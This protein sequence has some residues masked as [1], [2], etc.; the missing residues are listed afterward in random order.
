MNRLALGMMLVLSA[1]AGPTVNKQAPKPSPATPP[2][3]TFPDQKEPP[4]PGSLEALMK[5]HAG[6]LEVTPNNTI[7]LQMRDRRVNILPEKE[8]FDRYVIEL[9]R[10]L[11]EYEGQS[12]SPGLTLQ[13]LPPVTLPQIDQRIPDPGLALLAGA[14]R[15][16][17]KT[18]VNPTTGQKIRHRLADILVLRGEAALSSEDTGRDSGASQTYLAQSIQLYQEL[19]RDDPAD[20][21]ND[22]VL[23]QLA[24]AYALTGDSAASIAA[25]ARLSA[26][27]PDSSHIPEAEFRQAEN[28]F[29]S[30]DY[31]RADLAYTRVI[32]YGENTPYYINARYMQGWSRLE[33]G[34]YHGAVEPLSLTLDQLLPA[35]NNM[36]SMARGERELAQDSLRALAL[37]FSQLEGAASINRA[38]NRLGTRSYQ[39]LI[40]LQLGELYLSQERY[41]DSAETYKSYLLSFP[42]A[43]AAPGVQKQVIE[44]YEAGGF[45]ELVAQEKQRY[46]ELFGINATYWQHRGEEST[47]ENRLYVKQLTRE[48]ANYHHALAQQATSP[49]D[50]TLSATAKDHYLA[51]IH[52]YQSFVDH[53]AQD[54]FA[55]EMSFL[56]GEC[57]SQ[58]G[59]YPGAITAY[60]WAAYEHSGDKRAAE[61]AYA[62][63]LT[64]EHLDQKADPSAPKRRIASARRFAATLANDPRAPVVLEHAAASLLRLN[65]FNEST[66]LATKVIGWQPT[67]DPALLTAAHLVKGH[68]L[69]EMH[70]YTDAEQTYRQAL[71]GLSAND[72]RYPET[73]DRLAASIYR[74]GELAANAGNF[75]RAAQEFERV[76][77]AAP[78]SS[79]RISA[80]F[81]AAVNFIQAGELEHANRLLLDFRKR[82]PNHPLTASTGT[83]LLHNYEQLEQWQA[84]ATEL[85]TIAATN[86][87][88]EAGREAL[89]LSASYYERAGKTDLA[90]QRYRRYVQLWPK[91]FATALEAMNRLAE[92]YQENG[93]LKKRNF[94]LARIM[95]A[96][97]RAGSAQSERSLYL[98]ARASSI[99]A[100]LEYQ[101]FVAIKL[102]YPLQ[103]SLAH[104]R[105][106]L[107]RAMAAY[108]KTQAYG[109]QQFGT[110]ATYRM[111]RIYQQLSVDLLRS[112]RPRGLDALALQQYD[113]LLE[114]Q[115]YPFEEKAIAIYET[116]ARRGRDGL[117]DEWVR[118][119]FT[120]LAELLPAR[121]RKQEKRYGY[122]GEIY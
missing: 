83:K 99:L 19:L 42:D 25:L 108:Q 101:Q 64:Y 12:K 88:Q 72:D 106:A 22:Q 43:T 6:T 87:K 30:A 66:Q 68:S 8:A 90:V 103:K 5:Q 79:I 21:S 98:A 40:F 86:A 10:A 121:Y 117:Y 122:S 34:D 113:L 33:K 62:A 7:V 102:G 37:V 4:R 75:H 73:I 59:D 27:Y 78:L 17:L 67:P 69:F 85:D 120:A 20:P 54:E 77:S 81:D 63:I 14:Y 51:A 11:Q 112:Q 93:Q 70:R 1:C 114:E 60:E 45:P 49:D 26:A 91:P 96:H 41:L 109:V 107:T 100:D 116:N 24:R 61:A 13:G 35:D 18:N 56:L 110:L 65:L 74:Q 29:S 47:D 16:A 32:S 57:R 104:K 44:T 55:A 119:S 31:D 46:L 95:T 89:Y 23:Y 58:T 15:D 92:L 36:T 52:Y 115:A 105:T 53:F 111:G 118:K 84:A 48:L 38:Y 71:S 50:H 39:P 80:Q 76:I 9:L 3:V 97:D 2:P 82:Y 94:W 28:Y